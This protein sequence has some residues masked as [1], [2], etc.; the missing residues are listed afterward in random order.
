M[1]LMEYHVSFHDTLTAKSLSLIDRG[2]NGGVAGEDVRVIFRTH[3]TV[4]IKGIDNHHVN[5]IGIGTV[6]GVV[7]TQNG[8]VIAIMNQYALLGKGASIHSPG[9]LEWYK[10]EVNDKSVRVP[11]GLQRLV[12]LDGYIMPLTIKDGLARLDIRPHTDHEYETLPHVFLTS[13]LEWDPTVLDHEFTNPSEYSSNQHVGISN[14]SPYNSFGDYR[15]RIEVNKLNYYSR[16]DGDNI[17]DHIDRC[18]VHAHTSTIKDDPS[19]SICTKMVSKKS[20]DYTKLRPLFGWLDA[21]TVKHTF[22]NTTQYARL[23]SGTTLRRTFRSPNPALNVIRRNEAVACDIVYADVPAIDN[24][25]TMAVLFVGTD[26]QVTDVYGI[27]TDKQFVNTLE[28]V[29]T[30]RGAPHKLISDRAQVIISNKIQDILRTL[31]IQSWQSEPHQQQQNPAE[32]RYQ[33]I[34]RATNR[35]LDR[36]GA[37]PYTWFLCLQYVCYLLNHAYNNTLQG[38]PLQLLTGVTVDISA[39]LRFHFYQKVYYKSVDNG[40]PSDSVE[41][42]GYIV[43]ISEHCG[44]ALTYKVLNPSTLKVVYRSLLR[45]ADIDDLNHRADSLDGES[46]DVIHGRTNMKNDLNELKHLTTMKNAPVIDPDDLIG[47][48]FLLSDQPDGNKSRAC[49]VKLIEDHDHK[50]ETNK[51]R[52]K[53]LLSV[54]EDT[55]EEVITYNQLLDY[56]AKDDNNDVVWKFKRIINHEGPLSSKHPNFKGS[57][58]NIMIEWENGEISTEPLQIIAK[59]DP[60]TCAIY[61]KDNG[62]LDSP[63]WKQFKSIAK[64]QNTL[65]RMVNQAK[66]KS[67]NSAPKFKSGFQIPRHY[68]EAIRFDERNKN[69]KWQDAMLL[70]L[71]QISEYDTFINLGHH[72]SVKVPTDHKKIRVH[73]V[74]DVKHDGRHKA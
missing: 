27:K 56:L 2:A 33:T 62:L 40:F 51:D 5:D 58:Y 73:F 66:L 21:D 43:G 45:P 7:Q 48:S 8:P 64:R 71:Q 13:E 63:G 35:I 53:F 72:S 47:R 46:Q 69:S 16:F 23:P 41:V 26:T 50:V 38:I 54:N 36:S 25:A 52:I 6:G 32:R 18:V 60:V 19:L 42:T 29:I 37:P 39:L 14:D 11:G 15:H 61:A 55:S 20:P 59:D 31:C 24:G 67:Y 9:Q 12:T 49:I 3:R 4:D 10:N 1:A 65:T 28:D 57:S 44:H 30:H 68:A 22:E 34:K 70:E 74:Y 17:D